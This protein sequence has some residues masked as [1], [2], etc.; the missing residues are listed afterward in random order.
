[1]E[2]RKAPKSAVLTSAN[3]G[4]RLRQCCRAIND[5][6]QVEDLYRAFPSQVQ[7][8]VDKKGGRLTE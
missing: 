1:M 7:K 8:F 5:E 2:T 4:V 3:F 6:L